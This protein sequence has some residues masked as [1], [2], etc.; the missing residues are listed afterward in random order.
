MVCSV[1]VSVL[2]ATATYAI[3]IISAFR[4]SSRQDFPCRLLFLVPLLLPQ[5]SSAVLT[6]LLP[7]HSPPH[8]YR[9]LVKLSPRR[10]HGNG[11]S[12]DKAKS[13]TDVVRER[14]HHDDG[15]SNAQPYT[16]THTHSHGIF[17]GHSH[18]YLH[19]HDGHDHGRGL[20]ETLQREGAHLVPFTFLL[21]VL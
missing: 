10:I 6:H 8:R 7:S 5:F 1:I 16:H 19:G 17:G 13:P 14:E 11:E 18:S 20:I 12:A 2:T 4:A 21:Y 3:V 9:E 15:L